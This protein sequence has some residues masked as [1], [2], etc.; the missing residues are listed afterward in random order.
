MPRRKL[1]LVAAVAC[2]ALAGTRVLPAQEQSVWPP[3]GPRHWE[4]DPETAF[5]R[6]RKEGKS[7][8]VL[9]A[10]EKCPHCVVMARDAWPKQEVVNA[11]KDAVMLAIYRW[12]DPKSEEAED[13]EWAKRLNVKGYPQIRILDGWGRALPSTNGHEDARSAVDVA[14]AIKRSKAPP[15]KKPEAPKIPEPLA[16]H[17]TSKERSAAMNL[18][19]CVRARVWLDALTKGSWPAPDLVALLRAVDDPLVRIAAIERLGADMPKL[20]DPLLAALD[21]VLTGDNDYVRN[22][23]MQLLGKAGGPKAA[24]SLGAV[25]TKALDDRGTFQNNN[26]VLSEA[27]ETTIGMADKSLVD[28]LSRV[29]T[30]QEANNYALVV[31]V[32]SLVA[33]GRKSGAE[34]VR[35]PLEAARKKEGALANQIQREIGDLL[36]K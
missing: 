2:A 4:T 34:L 31:A 18:V 21:D 12:A 36:G 9:I 29:V 33:I 25:I 5:A 30:T 16:Q 14:A 28:V 1:G 35:E 10:T 32:K 8:F 15:K 26:N 22:A 13:S 27:V 24:Q 19:G 23:A 7:V 11:A 17:L 6:A 20:D 3:A